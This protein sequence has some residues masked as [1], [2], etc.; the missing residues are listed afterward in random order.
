MFYGILVAMYVLDMDRHHH[1]HIHV[2]YNEFKA[3]IQ[4]P[5]GELL[6]GK[7][8]SRQMKLLQAWLEIHRD[9]LMA[10]WHLAST[11]QTPFKIDP[12]R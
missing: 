11:G 3:V 2:R 5:D 7:L 6:D 8:P 4:I 10:D 9:E 1:P 12:L